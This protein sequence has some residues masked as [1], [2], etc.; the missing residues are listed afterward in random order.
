M[1]LDHCYAFGLLLLPSSLKKKF[2][3]E[4]NS[5]YFCAV[6]KVYL[7]INQYLNLEN[8][9]LWHM[10]QLELLTSISFYNSYKYFD[11]GRINFTLVDFCLSYIELNSTSLEFISTQVNLK[12]VK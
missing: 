5:T 6:C 2:V 9:I 10:F 3:E 1:L 8:Y 7:Y 4:L 12:M 11:V